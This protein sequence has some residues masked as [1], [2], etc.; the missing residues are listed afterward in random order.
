MIH[1][2]YIPF[3]S[4]EQIP[5]YIMVYDLRYVC[6]TQY[7]CVF[8]LRVDRDDRDD[9]LAQGS[10][11]GDRHARGAENRYLC[12]IY[13]RYYITF[14]PNRRSVTMQGVTI[15]PI[16]R[17]SRSSRIVTPF[18]VKLHFTACVTSAAVVANAVFVEQTA[19]VHVE[20]QH[21]RLGLHVC[22][23]H[24][25]KLRGRSRPVG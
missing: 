11:R 8:P 6:T 25:G 1:G 22:G 12:P 21:K 18:K 9:L 17:S 2:I 5:W 3:A 24:F 13:C 14:A 7:L 10:S 19:R 23:K 15:P 16:K 4:T 20:L